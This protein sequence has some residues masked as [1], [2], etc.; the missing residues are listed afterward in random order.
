MLKFLKIARL[1]SK[2]SE[3]VLCSWST[4]LTIL[5]IN[6][7]VRRFWDKFILLNVLSCYRMPYIFDNLA[8]FDRSSQKAIPS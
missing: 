8:S 1:Y 7:C 6:G 3:H 2:S 4:Q 5:S